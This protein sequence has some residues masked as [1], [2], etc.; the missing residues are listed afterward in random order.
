MNILI[1]DDH[2]EIRDILSK[3]VVEMGYN[4]SVAANGAE[5]IEEIGTKKIDIVLL[6]Y[7]LPDIKGFELLQD[8][9]SISHYPEVIMITGHANIKHS[10]QAMKI[11][12]ADYLVKPIDNEELEVVIQRCV[13]TIN[14]NREI[15]DLRNRV[16]EKISVREM[17]GESIAITKVLETVDL[18]ADK[19][20]TILLGGKT[21]T[22]KGL[23]AKL[24]HQKSTRKKGP[25]IAIDLGSVPESLFESELFGHEKGTF[26]GATSR[27]IGKFEEANRGT[28][29]LDEINN[30]PYNLQRKFLRAIEE[31]EIHRLGGN[32]TIKINT[33]IIVA[34]NK[35]LTQ[36]IKRGKFREDLFFRLQEFKIVLPDLFQRKDDIPILVDYFVKE[37]NRDFNLSIKGVSPEVMEILMNYRWKGNVRELKNAV[38]RATLLC[39]EKY[40]QEKDITLLS[41]EKMAWN[42]EDKINYF[43]MGDLHKKTLPEILI[44]KEKL[45]YEAILKQVDGNKIKAAKIAGISRWTLYR[46]LNNMG[47][48]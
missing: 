41:D 18:I 1:V 42:L 38:R 28:L 23:V 15:R 22:G 2:K 12:A 25:F 10:V 40:L 19:D 20:I 5:A 46:K 30:L 34:S 6:D 39:N 14:L 43:Y 33:R 44:E 24:I 27:R 11:G 45:I 4:V 35:E 31:R 48:E 21:G 47:I 32:R 37:A 8:I 29:F 17:M 16:N 9:L 13:K 26:T 3:V 7:Q 36:L